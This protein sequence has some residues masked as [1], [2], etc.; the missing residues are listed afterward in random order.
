[1]KYINVNNFMDDLDEIVLAKIE[2]EKELIENETIEKKFNINEFIQWINFSKSIFMKNDG[3][4]DINIPFSIYKSSNELYI[5]YVLYENNEDNI[6]ALDI[7]KNKLNDINF[8]INKLNKVNMNELF[9]NGLYKPASNY[10]II[11]GQM[12]I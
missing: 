8:N 4:I 9:E 10:F 12:Y 3:E 5:F 6:K 11:N 1:M 7:F 2:I